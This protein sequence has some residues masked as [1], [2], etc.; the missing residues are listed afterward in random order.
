M[1]VV[2]GVGIKRK[3]EWGAQ[4]FKNKRVVKWSVEKYNKEKSLSVLKA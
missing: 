3:I 2:T 1:R 4:V